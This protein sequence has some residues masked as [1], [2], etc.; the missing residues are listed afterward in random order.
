MTI[1]T[2]NLRMKTNIKLL[3]IALLISAIGFSQKEVIKTNG[4]EYYTDSRLNDF[5]G[6][7][8]LND[9]TK[10]FR[11]K[12]VPKR[13]DLENIYVD[14]L[15][16][17]Y[18]YSIEGDLI[19]NTIAS[20]NPEDPN[21][22]KS[23]GNIENEYENILLIKFWDASFEKLGTARMSF[24]NEEKTRVKWKLGNYEREQVRII[25]A[26]NSYREIP[27]GFS[28][29]TEMILEKVDE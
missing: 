17:Y 26:D 11:I 8:Q 14:L 2:K 29:P 24:L 9:S 28:V 12:L 15:M 27:K 19:S 16:G 20:M 7:W 23:S 13:I 5:I 22:R 25:T 21:E 6:I 18:L 10:Q 3:L 1:A 4:K